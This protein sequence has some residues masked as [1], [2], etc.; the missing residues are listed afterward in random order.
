MSQT[1]FLKWRYIL[2]GVVIMHET[3]NELHVQKGSGVLFKIDFEK[4]F[5]K[6]NW[7]FLL[8]I[9]EMKGFPPGWINL[10]MNTVRG[11]KVAIRVNDDTGPYFCTHQGLRQGD[12]LS[13]L[14]FDLAADALAI[15]ITRAVDSGILKGLCSR[16]VE[17]GVSILQYVDDTILLL[18]DD[19]EQARN[20][21]FVLCLFEQ[22]SGLKINFHK[23]EVICL[24]NAKER[25]AD[26]EE[27]FTCKAGELPMK[28]LGIPIDEK[29]LSLKDWK[30]VLEK[31]EN[32]L[33]CWQG[34]NLVI[35]GR[36]TLINSSLL[37]LLLYMLSFYRVPVGVKHKADSIESNFSV[38]W[39][40]E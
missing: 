14:L 16:L 32:K 8:Q 17:K 23:S 3:L 22:M 40:Q 7:T 25:C 5:D 34:K 26:F 36:S 18:E 28:Y 10:V 29:R 37:S 30:P 21:K 13:P 39:G 1:A 11:G 20:L 24:G 9:L 19:L 27:I 12:P 15:M 35:G 31:H 6:V 38:E 2:E 33:S 4:A